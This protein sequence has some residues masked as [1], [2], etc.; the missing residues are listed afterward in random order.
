[1]DRVD[2]TPNLIIVDEAHHATGKTTWGKVLQFYSRAKVLGVT[3]TPARLDGQGLGVAA[4]GFFDAMV[5]GPSVADLTAQGYLS[6]AVVYAPKTQLDLSGV[7]TRGGDYAQNELAAAMDKA[8]ITGDS[9]A[10][11]R[12]NCDGQPA[13]AFCASVAHAEHVAEAFRA[14]G[15]RAASVDGGMD[16]K[17]RADRVADL[18]NGRLQVL[19]S[20]DIISEGVDIPIVSAAI[21]LRPTQSLSLYLQQV[22]RV[23]RPFPG[24]PHATINDHV[25][26]VFR[27]GLPDDDREWSLEGK[28]KGKKKTDND[29]VSVKQCEQCYTVHR[30]APVCPHCGFVYRV[31]SR[32]IEQVAGELEQVQRAPVIPPEKLAAKKEQSSAR[33]LEDLVEIGRKRGYPHPHAWASHVWKSRQARGMVAA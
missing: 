26:N 25:G 31:Q 4:D 10:T 30:P 8:T 6:P 2:W 9:V 13:I 24:K 21:L 27:H 14:A 12:K 33:S 15:Y 16:S 23:L 1:M 22:G 28:P 29:A 17:T 20:C 19:T 11:Y 32:E 3:A 7:K 5:M 18:G